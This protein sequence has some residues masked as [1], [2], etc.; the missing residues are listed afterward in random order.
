M[1]ILASASPT[2]ADMLRAAGVQIEVDPASVD[3]DAIKAAMTAE[4][5][6]PRDVADKL[7]EMKALRASARHPDAPVLGADQ[8][9]VS[10]GALISKAA[11]MDEA[12]AQLMALRGARHELLSAAVIVRN[13]A[14]VWRHVGVARLHVRPF[15]EAFLDDYLAR[16]GEDVLSTVGGYRLEGLGAQLFAR[17]DGDHFSVLGLPLLEVLGYLRTQ[18]LLR[19]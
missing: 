7:A 2:R 16:L 17:V 9:L 12:R 1:L 4:G 3:E 19:E 14:P 10:A 8:V 18:G 13:G 11:D 15:G 5:A 6:P